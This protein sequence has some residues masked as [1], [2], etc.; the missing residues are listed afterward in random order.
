LDILR[1]TPPPVQS[2]TKKPT[3]ESW[4]PTLS[5]SDSDAGSSSDSELMA[6]AAV[7]RQQ[8]TERLR[9]FRP[10][11]QN[12]F[13]IPQW[14]FLDGE[15]NEHQENLVQEYRKRLG[16]SYPIIYYSILYYTI[17]TMLC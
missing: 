11:V 1:C 12:D 14:R 17:C 5:K 13:N 7:S 10:E 9:F 15:D 2:K 4:R 16:V 3:F 6:A 8:L